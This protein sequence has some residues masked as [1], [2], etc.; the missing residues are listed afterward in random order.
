VGLIG[1]SL[2]YDYLRRRY[3]G[4][5]GG[6]VPAHETF[7]ERGTTKFQAQFG[8]A[9]LAELSGKSVVDFGCGEGAAAIELALAGCTR[10][11]GLDIIEQRLMIARERA[12]QLGVS[13]RVTFATELA[14]PA[15]VVL[16]MDAFEHFSDPAA[17]LTR[18]SELLRPGGYALVSF[19]P[20]WYHPLGGHLFSV[21]PWAHLVFTERVLMRWRSDFKVDGA[22]RFSEVEGGLNQMTIARWLKLVAA[23]PLRIAQ[24]E[25]VP[26]RGLRRAHS[27]W[28]REFTTSL[29]KARLVKK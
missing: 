17:I 15:D 29:V 9:A 23:S 14:Q 19:G 26:I 24:L 8:P 10:V 11:T 3:P 20:T 1:T 22:T 4:G 5:E 21:F 13:D 2:A 6:A 18:I 16:S 12:A 7:V 25:L 28:T 27:R